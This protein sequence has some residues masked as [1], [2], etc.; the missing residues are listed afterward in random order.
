VWRVVH[1]PSVDAEEQRHRH[2]DLETLKQERA[3]TTTR[4][5]GWLRSQGVR[6]RSLSKWPAHLEA[7]R[8]WESSPLP[9]GRRR[10]VR[11]VYA[12]PQFLSQQ[13]AELEAER[14]ALLHT[15]QAAALEKVRQVRPLR[16][17]GIKGAWFLVMAFF[18]GRAC[19]HRR[20]VGG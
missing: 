2:R 18:G 11:R 16:G 12:Q 5:K 14:R 3:R 20:E 9:S 1:V 13:M 15:S 8:L 17:M 10:R 6:L 4:I 7:W 19:K